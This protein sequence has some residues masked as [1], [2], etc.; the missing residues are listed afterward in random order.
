[1]TDWAMTLD[2]V[3]HCPI[4]CRSGAFRVIRGIDRQLLERFTLTSFGPL[5]L[6]LQEVSNEQ[7]MEAKISML[8]SGSEVCVWR[9]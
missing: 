3:T 8:E 4:A 7:G 2:T 9:V 6:I 1:M 5:L